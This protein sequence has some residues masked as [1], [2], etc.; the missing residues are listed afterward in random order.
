M[1]VEVSVMAGRD[2][3]LLT[4][5]LGDVMKESARAALTYAKTHAEE[6]G[7]PDDMLTGREIHVHVPAGAVPK[8]GPSAGV[9]MA[10]ALVSALSGRP[11]RHDVA[12]TGE[13]TLSGRILPIGGVKEKVLGA[14]RAGITTVILP[15]ENLADLDEIGE[16][17][18]ESL[19][20]HAIEDLEEVL[21]IA[22]LESS[23][24]GVLDPDDE[25]GLVASRN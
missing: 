3:L 4:G 23:L 22:L 21:E 12:M 6:L 24:S 2:D 15:K 11:V 7:I 5:Q 19:T 14:C 17:Q 9:T 20:V 18:R 10:T 8:D 16:K 13:V 1:F 25:R